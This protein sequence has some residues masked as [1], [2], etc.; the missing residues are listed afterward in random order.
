MRTVKGP[1]PLVQTLLP[2][3]LVAVRPCYGFFTGQSDP[4][5]TPVPPDLH[6]LKNLS[7][8]VDFV[9]IENLSNDE[10][11]I[12][13][14][15]GSCWSQILTLSN[16]TDPG[17]SLVISANERTVVKSIYRI[18]DQLLDCDI[19]GEGEVGKFVERFQ[20]EITRVVNGGHYEFHWMNE[21]NYTMLSMQI[22]SL[23]VD[24]QKQQC[25]ELHETIL[26]AATNV[27]NREKRWRA[28]RHSYNSTGHRLRH[29]KRSKRFLYYPGT[30]WCGTGTRAKSA[31]QFGE[32]AEADKCCRDH[33]QCPMTINSFSQKYKLI[34]PFAFTISQCDCD[35]QYANL[36]IRTNL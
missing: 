25:L 36:F 1:Y 17:V 31:D 18:D 13:T 16:S 6:M 2:L 12:F 34:N 28:S 10:K 19:L 8:P 11:Q 27:T 23:Q 14:Q 33:D 30:Y 15:N 20:S 4:A 5:T 7:D 22:Q 35:K 32:H 29:D 3:L 21:T 9:V 24:H 26:Q